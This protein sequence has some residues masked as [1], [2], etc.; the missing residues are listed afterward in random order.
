MQPRPAACDT[1][2]RGATACCLQVSPSFLS[3]AVST[4]SQK[5]TDR[6]W[7]ICILAILR[8]SLLL[9]VAVLLSTK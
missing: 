5:H 9:A 3:G 1:M 4:G 2:G 6:Q 8:D 7:A